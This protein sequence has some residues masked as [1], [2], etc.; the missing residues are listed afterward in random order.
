MNE[1][2]YGKWQSVRMFQE[3]GNVSRDAQPLMV[4]GHATS[5]LVVVLGQGYPS[6]T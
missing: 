4:K 3:G 1:M 5:P 2:G 6:K